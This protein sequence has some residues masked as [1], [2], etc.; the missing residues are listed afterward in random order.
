M[1]ISAGPAQAGA[2]LAFGAPRKEGAG[3]TGECVVDGGGRISRGLV[4][5]GA[6]AA[7]VAGRVGEFLQ[8]GGKALPRDHARARPP[9]FLAIFTRA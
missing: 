1:Q 9:T 2:P 4:P 8:H 7:H 3:G 5:T 6:P